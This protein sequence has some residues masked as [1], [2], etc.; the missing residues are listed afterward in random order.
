M[1]FQ[2][3]GS[4]L[5]ALE[6]D[7]K[8]EDIIMILMNTVDGHIPEPERDT[9]KT[10]IKLPKTYS[11]S[12]V[13]VHCCFSGTYRPCSVVR[14]NDLL[15]SLVLKKKNQKAVVTGVEMFL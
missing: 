7:S 1:T 12:L 10:I 13:A 8:Y 2:L 9:D 6:G 14:V 15:K 11:Q 5:K 3:S 4:A